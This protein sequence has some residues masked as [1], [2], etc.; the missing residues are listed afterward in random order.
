MSTN[1]HLTPELKRFAEEC[2]ASGRYNNVSEVVRAGLRL[3]QDAEERKRA[4]MR[5]LE[6]ARAES[7]RDGWIEIDDLAAEMDARL[8]AAEKRGDKSAA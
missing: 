7:D 6:E 8:Q 5:S 1:V 2:V 4:F 3:V